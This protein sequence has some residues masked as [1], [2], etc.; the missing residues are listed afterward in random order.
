MMMKMKLL[1]VGVLTVV[2]SVKGDDISPCETASTAIVACLFTGACPFEDT[3][4]LIPLPELFE[5]DCTNVVEECSHIR[6]GCCPECQ[7]ALVGVYQE[8]DICPDLDCE[9]VDTI[10]VEPREIPDCFVASDSYLNCV[11]TNIDTPACLYCPLVLEFNATCGEREAVLCADDCCDVCKPLL[12]DVIET[13]ELFEGQKDCGCNFSPSAPTTLS[14]AGAPNVG[15]EGCLTTELSAYQF[16]MMEN[17]KCD[18]ECLDAAAH[19]FS[20]LYL[21]GF[22]TCGDLSESCDA[23][24]TCCPACHEAFNETMA[25]L[26]KVQ[27]GDTYCDGC[28]NAIT[29]TAAP[30]PAPSVD[31]GGSSAAPI[32]GLVWPRSMMVLIGLVVGALVTF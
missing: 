5:V 22:N 4:C 27:F 19:A 14:P 28:Q 7:E 10:D 31:N 13:C 32:S 12:A 8:C 21:S 25:C 11:I 23:S 9:G 30:A 20:T 24:L 29:Q 1:F 2:S 17:P 16:C 18:S 6:N 3:S 15:S 26:G